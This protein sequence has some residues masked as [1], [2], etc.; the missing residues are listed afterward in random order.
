MISRRRAVF[1]GLGALAAVYLLALQRDINGSGDPYMIDVGEIQVAL[2]LWGTVHHTGYPLY[3]VLGASLVSLFKLV[4]VNPAASA[5]LVSWV[6]GAAALGVMYALLDARRVRP[7]LAALL[8]MALGLTRSFWIHSVVAEVYSLYALFV[9]LAIWWVF[10]DARRWQMRDWMVAALIL[11]LGVGHHRA[12]AFVVP[13]LAVWLL[14]EMRRVRRRMP[15]ILVLGA[16]IFA[17]TFVVYLYMPMRDWAGARWVYGQPG[18]WE[19]FLHEFLGREAQREMDPPH[20]LAD[21]FGHIGYILEVLAGQLTWPGVVLG[22]AVLGVLAAQRDTRR[23]AWALAAGGFAYLGFAVWLPEAV[24][25]PAFLM[26]VSMLLVL[27][28]GEASVC[29]PQMSL[30]TAGGVAL[31]AVLAVGNGPFVLSLTCDPGGREVI[32]RVAALPH[33]EFEREPVLML[34]W[35]GSYF[36]VNYGR[37]VTG[38]L[39]GFEPVDHRADFGALLARGARLITLP[40]TFYVFPL[41][42][43]NARLGRTYLTSAAPGFIQIRDTPVRMAEDEAI[44]AMDNGI[45]LLAYTLEGDH[46]T[47]FWRAN[48]APDQSYRVFVHLTRVAEPAGP[49]DILAQYDVPAPVYGRYPTTRWTAGEVVREDYILA[50]PP[51]ARYLRVGMYRALPDAHFENFGALVRRLR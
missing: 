3:T 27:A 35:G 41:R 25:A 20:S 24:L 13:G 11:G 39:E 47:L 10:K 14:P 31:V 29:L 17:A 38:R 36:A 26:P 12:V 9:A 18:T 23:L 48:R 46:L 45:S 4:G 43:W 44:A 40:E 22:A 32:E 8:M 2:N 30:Q 21:L 28:A 37:W 6:F 15:F 1:L 33:D 7:A 16:L 34:P 42:W 51:E 5:S 19:G 50:P 49:A